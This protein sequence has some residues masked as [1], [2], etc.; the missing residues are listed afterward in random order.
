M[1]RPIPV[2]MA[3]KRRRNCR[4]RG[5]RL[6]NKL[7]APEANILR[8]LEKM[9][10]GRGRHGGGPRPYLLR[11]EAPCLAASAPE[12]EKVF[13]PNFIRR[14]NR[15]FTYS[16]YREFIRKL[17]IEVEF[18]L[19]CR[20]QREFVNLI[21]QVRGEEIQVQP[22]LPRRARS[23]RRRQRRGGWEREDFFFFLV[24]VAGQGYVVSL[25]TVVAASLSLE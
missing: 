11:T 20:F 7:R 23:S 24:G 6:P 3:M 19:G 17:Q 18:D 21:Y 1:P 14:W 9:Y 10:A 16:I 2:A 15:L 13:L 5:A 8:P 12:T 25:A 22:T 4:P